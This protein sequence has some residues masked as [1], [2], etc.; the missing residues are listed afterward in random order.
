MVP[1]TLSNQTF[2]WGE[3]ERGSI[4]LQRRFL[5]D[6]PVAEVEPVSVDDQRIQSRALVSLMQKVSFGYMEQHDNN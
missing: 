3:H 5:Y 6:T 4:N 1:I 2:F